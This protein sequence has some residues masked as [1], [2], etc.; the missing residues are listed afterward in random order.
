MGEK[1]L[2]LQIVTPTL[3]KV[4]EGADM[5]IMR[6]VDGEMGV[7][8]GHKPLST[9]LDYGV[10]RVFNNGAE[11]KIAVYGGLAMIKNNLLTV[12]TSGADWPEE[13]DYSQATADR[14]QARQRLQ[15][16]VDDMEIQNDEVL[17]RRALV[18]IE[19]SSQAIINEAVMEE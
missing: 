1:K 10:L 7:M 6:C 8:P 3:M 9:V 5:V 11:N 16:K 14:E 17:L 4:D 15:E 13:I 12:L 18:Q 2:R 19:V